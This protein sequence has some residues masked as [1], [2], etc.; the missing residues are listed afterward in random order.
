MSK[1]HTIFSTCLKHAKHVFFILISML[2][3][4][5]RGPPLTADCNSGDIYSSNVEFWQYVLYM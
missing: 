4:K 2:Y 5:T 1:P 3:A